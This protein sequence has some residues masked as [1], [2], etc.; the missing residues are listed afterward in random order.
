M[1]RMPVHVLA[2]VLFIASIAAAATA[3]PLPDFVYRK[4]SLAKESDPKI[5]GLLK[6]ASKIVYEQPKTARPM[7]IEAFKLMAG[8]NP[9]EEYD[10]IYALYLLLKSSYEG[11]GSNTLDTDAQD[12]FPKVGRVLFEHLDTGG[13]LGTFVFTP[14]GQFKMEAYVLAGG[15]Y[16]WFLYEDADGDEGRLLEALGVI[17]RTNRFVNAPSQ[18]YALD[19]EVRVLLALKRDAEAYKIVRKVLAKVPDFG[20]FADIKDSAAYKSWLRRNRE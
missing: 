14:I 10:Y 8:G 19:T 12:D 9:V 13:S 11:P 6:D 7:A 2:A 1:P 15:A 3:G 18:Y 17:Q 4:Y 16:G 20:D 5:A